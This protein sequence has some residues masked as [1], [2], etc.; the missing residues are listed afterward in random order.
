MKNTKKHFQETV[1]TK[2][3]R[4]TSIGNRSI[5]SASECSPNPKRKHTVRPKTNQKQSPYKPH[6]LPGSDKVGFEKLTINA[7]MIAQSYMMAQTI[8]THQTARKISLNRSTTVNLEKSKGKG[9]LH[10]IHGHGE[11]KHCKQVKGKVVIEQESNNNLTFDNNPVDSPEKTNEKLL[12][13]DVEYITIHVHDD[14]KN[15]TEDFCCHKATL[16]AEMGYFEKYLKTTSSIDEI[17]ISIH[18]DIRIFSWLT[19]YLNKRKIKKA[20]Y[21]RYNS[22]HQNTRDIAGL[23][24]NERDILLNEI[25]KIMTPEEIS[26]YKEPQLSNLIVKY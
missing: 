10:T 7:P 1:L 3:A 15:I 2:H 22:L 18:C 4:L 25:Q 16:L 21:E 13:K 24:T 19:K 12:P 5:S 20:V 11:V 23:S 8:K 9:T 14:I 26:I 17:D 6:T